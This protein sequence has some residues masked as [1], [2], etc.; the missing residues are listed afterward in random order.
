VITHH[1]LRI[2][3]NAANPQ[4]TRK[5]IRLL[6]GAVSAIDAFRQLKAQRPGAAHAR[7]VDADEGLQRGGGKDAG[8]YPLRAAP[9]RHI[10]RQQH[11]QDHF[12]PLDH[13]GQ[14]EC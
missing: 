13:F 5:G 10:D 7:F 8:Q 14:T 2:T 9:L 11:D 12:D 6:E 4:K 1:A 3:K